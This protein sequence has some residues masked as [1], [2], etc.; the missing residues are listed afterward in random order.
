MRTR[1]LDCF[2]SPHLFLFFNFFSFNWFN[3]TI[4]DGKSPK[5]FPFKRNSASCFYCIS[6]LLLHSLMQWCCNKNSLP[7]FQEKN[8]AM[9]PPHQRKNWT[10][11]VNGK[12]LSPS[13]VAQSGCCFQRG[14]DTP[15]AESFLCHRQQCA[16]TAVWSAFIYRVF[17]CWVEFTADFATFNMKKSCL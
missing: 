2:F 10:P 15:V 5:I 12:G 17:F 7:Y 13:V 9:Q 14:R 11:E 1:I 6:C 8:G 16:W 4:T 3:V